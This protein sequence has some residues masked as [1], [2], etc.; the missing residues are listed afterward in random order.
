MARWLIGAVFIGMVVLP[1]QARAQD[2][3][4]YSLEF[5]YTVLTKRS[6]IEREIEFKFNYEKGSE[7]RSFRMG[8]RPRVGDPAPVANRAGDPHRPAGPQ[9]GPQRGRDR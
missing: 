6:V 4:D 7:G 8:R 9:G 3:D 2:D 1:A 5:A